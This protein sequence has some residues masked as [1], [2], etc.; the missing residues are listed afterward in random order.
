[1]KTKYT[2]G[3]WRIKQY[4]CGMPLVEFDDLGS[5]A[6][7]CGQ[8][9]EANAKLIASAPELLNRLK[10]LIDACEMPWMKTRMEGASIGNDVE[11]SL[12]DARETIRKATGE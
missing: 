12:K 3:P 5:Y 2:P 7:V 8:N 6:S 1:M 9:K 4:D 10:Q 11:V